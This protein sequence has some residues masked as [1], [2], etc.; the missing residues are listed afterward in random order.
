MGVVLYTVL[1]GKWPYVSIHMLQY[2]ND[3][4]LQEPSEKPKLSAAVLQFPENSVSMAAQALIAKLLEE[5][6]HKRAGYAECV[7]SDWMRAQTNSK[8]ILADSSFV[9]EITS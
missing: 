4:H 5:D 3:Q 2:W 8:W 9:Y 7:A 6:D 1:V